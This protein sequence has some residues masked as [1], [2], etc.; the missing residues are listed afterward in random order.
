MEES[1][2]F[3]ELFVCLFGLKYMSGST[4]SSGTSNEAKFTG[5]QET[6]GAMKFK[7]YEPS[8]CFCSTKLNYYQTVTNSVR[9]ILSDSIKRIITFVL[10]RPC[11]RFSV[12]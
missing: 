5:L 2:L 4:N 11:I 7:I 3:R 9:E 6:I 8:P 1:V 10:F 12:A